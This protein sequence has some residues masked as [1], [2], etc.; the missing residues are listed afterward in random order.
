MLFNNYMLYLLFTTVLIFYYNFNKDIF[1]T[2]SGNIVIFIYCYFLS[3]DLYFSLFFNF[4]N[5]FFINF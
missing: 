3:N 1:S 4:I 5:R 2:F